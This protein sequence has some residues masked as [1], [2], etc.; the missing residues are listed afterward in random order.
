MG[1]IDEQLKA[2]ANKAMVISS[3]EFLVRYDNLRKNN[4]KLNDVVHFKPFEDIKKL[5][6]DN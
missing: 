2:F 6:E 1:W 4:T 5:L 3:R